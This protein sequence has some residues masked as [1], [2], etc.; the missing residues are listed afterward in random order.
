MF[1]TLMGI[2]YIVT[3]NDNVPIGYTKV[4]GDEKRGIYKNDDV[5]PL[6][7]STSKLMSKKYF[8]NLLHPY[9]SE[10]LLNNIVVD[11]DDVTSN[12]ISNITENEIPYSIDEDGVNKRNDGYNV[13]LSDQK[14][15]TLNLKETVTD[16]ILFVS[17]IIDEPMSCKDGDI[18]ISINNIKNTLTCAE[19]LYFNNNYTFDYVISSNSDIDKLDI[20]LSKGLYEIIKIK[21]YTLDYNK[22]KESINAFDKLVVDMNKTKGN[23]IEGEIN[24]TNDGY[25]AT[26]IPYD[27]GYSIYLDNK[28]IGY[29]KVNTAFIGF[30][31]TKGNHSIRIVY[32]SPGY[33]A[34]LISSIIGLLLFSLV[35]I[36]EKRQKN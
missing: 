32:T 4:S 1:E 34:G 2:K 23:I 7:Y 20:T 33:K 15:I 10:A 13:N 5:L 14:N 21:V 27:K 29:E 26:T 18:R 28:K 12:Y 6:G 35:I 8:D 31:I 16:K 9:R 24:V 17:F 3:S 36:K 30:P 25:F 22:I 19:W 11:D